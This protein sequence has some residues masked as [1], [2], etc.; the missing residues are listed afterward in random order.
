[1]RHALV[2][3]CALALGVSAAAQ[4][5]KPPAPKPPSAAGEDPVFARYAKGVLIVRPLRDA[6]KSF[7]HSWRW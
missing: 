7:E 5:P 3:I 1:M 4:A 6:P 2:M